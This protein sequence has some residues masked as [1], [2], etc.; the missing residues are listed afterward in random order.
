M[1]SIRDKIN[2]KLNISPPFI[3]PTSQIL[4]SYDETNI[5]IK[6]VSGLSQLCSI[7]LDCTWL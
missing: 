6:V 5:K 4:T 3:K 1:S 7:K 2:S